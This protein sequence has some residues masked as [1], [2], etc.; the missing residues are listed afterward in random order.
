MDARLRGDDD[1]VGNDGEI[2]NTATTPPL[3]AEAKPPLQV[4]VEQELTHILANLLQVNGNEINT[5]Q[6]IAEY[7]LDSIV[8][9]AYVGKINDTYDLNFMPMALADYP[10]I[11]AFA[12]Y[13]CREYT[14]ALEDYYA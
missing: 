2:Q 3:A 4:K 12:D 5:A 1:G 8:L 11:S 7:N 9:T 10:T 13:L 14:E 6:E